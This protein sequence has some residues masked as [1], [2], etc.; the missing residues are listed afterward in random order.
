[1]NASSVAVP[2]ALVG[3]R[4]VLLCDLAAL[5][6]NYRT[7]AARLAAVG[8]TPICV[9]KA[10]AYGHGAAPVTAALRAEGATRFAV[11]TL[12]EALAILPYL[13]GGE[14]LVLGYTP[15]E[16]APLA[17]AA[18]VTL[19]V[20]DAAYAKALS[21]TLKGPP[22]RV[23][24][25]L[26]SGMNRTGFPLLPEAFERTLRAVADVA[27]SARLRLT[28]LYSHLADADAGL[29][30]SVRRQVARVRAARLALLRRGIAPRAHLS[31][32]AGVAYGGAFGLPF[33]RVGL[34]LYGY[35]PGGAPLSP[36]VPVSRLMAR[37]AQVYP[38]PRG[39][40]VGYG[41]T[42]RTARRETVGILTL[43]YA[44][45][46]PRAAEGACLSVGGHPCPLIGRISMDAAAVLL[47]GVPRHALTHATVFGETAEQLYALSE[48]A[49]TIPYE[50]LARL[51][52]RIDR[53][54]LY[55]DDDGYPHSE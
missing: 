51:G 19:T 5:R 4:A 39:E 26:N 30:P 41:G 43:G 13:A 36:L 2:P 12:P 16:D 40:A 21:Q 42:Y 27:A 9:V 35:A 24:V 33:A 44:D 53:K 37:L 31:A 52:Q 45:G 8:A 25:K 17:A 15:P 1:M 34:A 20:P 3:R 38:L 23:A 28:D 7:V 6:Q 49:G 54:Y 46:L 32:T 29:T 55:A 11:A 48:A 10:D 47:T 18:G 22:L 50:L 14:V